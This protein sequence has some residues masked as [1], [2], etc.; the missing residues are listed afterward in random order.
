[1]SSVFS[2]WLD[3]YWKAV[4]ETSILEIPIAAITVPLKT[5]GYMAADYLITPDKPTAPPQSTFTPAAPRSRAELTSGQWTP[6]DAIFF[7]QEE[8]RNQILAGQ[9]GQGQKDPDPEDHTMWILGGI[10]LAALL[11]GLALRG[12]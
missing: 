7:G 11:G 10:G 3:A 12:R 8:T 9:A 2:N 1:M 5:G 4:K 6:D